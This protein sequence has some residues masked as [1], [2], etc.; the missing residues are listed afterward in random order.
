[1]EL[2]D[3][4]VF[5]LLPVDMYYV[6]LEIWSIVIN[7]QSFRCDLK[8]VLYCTQVFGWFTAVI[9]NLFINAEP[10]NICLYP[11]VPPPPTHLF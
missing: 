3:L 8:L 1:M 2:E 11:A 5:C 4:C 6:I 7:A 9:P 10:Y